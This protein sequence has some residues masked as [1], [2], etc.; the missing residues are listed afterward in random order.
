[1]AIWNWKG[2]ATIG[3]SGQ[4]ISGGA[5]SPEGVVTGN[6]GDVWFRTDGGTAS[7]LW[8]K[9]SGSGNTGWALATQ[10]SGGFTSPMTT[11]GDMIYSS[12]GSTP[13]RIGIGS[14]GQVLTV[15]GGVPVWATAGSTNSVIQTMTISS[16]SN[17]IT[18]GTA[19]AIAGDGLAANYYNGNSHAFGVS[20]DAGNPGDTIR[21]MTQGICPVQLLSTTDPS[22]TVIEG[23]EFIISQFGSD[24]PNQFARINDT[25]YLAAGADSIIGVALSTPDPI[26]NLF[27]ALIQVAFFRALQILVNNDSTINQNVINFID[28]PGIQIASDTSGNLTIGVGPVGI[29]PQTS[30]YVAVLADANQLTI[31]DVAGANTFMVPTNASVAFPIGTTL[32]VIQKN[33]GQV[34]LTPAG[35]VTINTP[36]S[37]T[38]RAQWSTVSVVKIA[39]DTWVA[40]GDLT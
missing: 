8:T 2:T 39:T 32:S 4:Q 40:G 19:M 28:G 10:G 27:T 21:I 5:G 13:V 30:S 7:V 33:T 15:V 34:T 9:V 31:M 20:L 36:S 6:V 14:T 26:T 12:P 35:G 22:T 18:A 23:D 1:M 29:N 25:D 24:G 37:W 16:L 3:T 17:P 11:T 38:T